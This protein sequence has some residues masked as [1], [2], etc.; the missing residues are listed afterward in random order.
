MIVCFVFGVPRKNDKYAK[1]YGDERYRIPLA[2]RRE[3][4]LINRV[5]TKYER[6]LYSLVV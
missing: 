2:F 3:L 4:V 5:R 1:Q 6:I